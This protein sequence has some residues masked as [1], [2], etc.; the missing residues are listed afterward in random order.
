MHVTVT[1][2]GADVTYD[3]EPRTL[4]VHYIRDAAGLKGTNVG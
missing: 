1:L 4:L 3:V 2:N